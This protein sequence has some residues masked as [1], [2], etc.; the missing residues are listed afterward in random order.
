MHVY[1]N[2]TL[3]I[4]PLNT[5]LWPEDGPQWPKHVVVSK[6]NRIQDS[7]VL[8]YTTPSLI[9]YNTTG[10][11]HPRL[12]ICKEWRSIQHWSLKAGSCRKRK[13]KQIY[14][15]WNDAFWSTCC[16]GPQYILHL[17]SVFWCGC[18]TG[19][20]DLYIHCRFLTSVS[21]RACERD[22]QADGQKEINSVLNGL[23]TCS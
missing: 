18:V 6:I 5:F 16:S 20:C 19:S 4:F 2:H 17:L 23:H 21:Q 14:A 15:T 12:K 9:A 13:G 7:C 3:Y 1:Y 11:M 22:M 8:N 10:M